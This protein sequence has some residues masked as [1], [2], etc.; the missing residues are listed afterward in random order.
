KR[1][2]AENN[3]R[4]IKEL[5]SNDLITILSFMDISKPEI[6]NGEF[7]SLTNNKLILLEAMLYDKIQHHN[8]SIETLTKLNS[9][10][11]DFVIQFNSLN[12]PGGYQLLKEED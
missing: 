11:K 6:E 5:L 9:K 10:L 4:K 12:N 1:G 7:I 2:A 8:L 3:L